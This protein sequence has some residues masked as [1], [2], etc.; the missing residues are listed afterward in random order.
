M[1]SLEASEKCQR[2][3]CQE[4]LVRESAIKA[5]DVVLD[6]CTSTS[7]SVSLCIQISKTPFSVEFK[8]NVTNSSPE[9]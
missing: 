3:H 1:G 8:D 9:C 6:N 5:L 4:K 7:E 2:Y